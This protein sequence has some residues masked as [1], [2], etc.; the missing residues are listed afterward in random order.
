MWI[1]QCIVSCV[2]TIERTKYVNIWCIVS[3]HLY[4]KKA[5]GWLRLW[6]LIPRWTI[7]QLYRGNQLC[8]WGTGRNPP[9]CRKFQCLIYRVGAIR[10]NNYIYFGSHVFVHFYRKKQVSLWSLV[11]VSWENSSI[12]DLLCEHRKCYLLCKLIFDLIM[13][14]RKIIP[15]PIFCVGT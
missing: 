3:V 4:S 1:F 10:Q 12:L 8:C 13:S 11:S 9:T 7:F 15:P 6:C 14:V 2:R 5:N